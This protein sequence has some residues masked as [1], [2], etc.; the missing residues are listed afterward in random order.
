MRLTNNL[1]NIQYQVKELPCGK[2][3]GKHGELGAMFMHEIFKKHLQLIDNSLN[4]RSEDHGTFLTNFLQEIDIYHTYFEF[5][6]YFA[7]KC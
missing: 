5:F 3:A 6:R 7:Q 1:K 4:I 2:W